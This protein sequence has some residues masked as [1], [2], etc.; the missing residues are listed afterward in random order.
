MDDISIAQSNM[1]RALFA[2]TEQL[3]GLERG[4]TPY[5]VRPR[6]V[7]K[8]NYAAETI[9]YIFYEVAALGEGSWWLP[10]SADEP[11]QWHGAEPLEADG[12]IPTAH[13]QRPTHLLWWIPAQSL[14]TE[15]IP[16]SI[17][18]RI[19]GNWPTTAPEDNP[20]PAASANLR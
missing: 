13:L 8:A 17:F 7:Q 2:T 18:G 12:E 20:P 10:V 19:H 11:T 4:I 14:D 6:S 16:I 3:L 9:P 15:I 1:T 5:L